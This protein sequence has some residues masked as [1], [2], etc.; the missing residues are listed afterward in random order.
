MKVQ[1]FFSNFFIK[2]KHFL[3]FGKEYEMRP[4]L[5]CLST[6]LFF[7]IAI[8]RIIK[9]IENALLEWKMLFR[10]CISSYSPMIAIQKKRKLAPFETLCSENLKSRLQHE[11]YK[12]GDSPLGHETVRNVF[13]KLQKYNSCFLNESS[14]LRLN[15]FNAAITGL[16]LFFNS[17]EHQINLDRFSML[18]FH[19]GSRKEVLRKLE[20]LI[21][22]V[23]CRRKVQKV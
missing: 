11:E 9:E 14:V 6:Y 7:R 1:L 8:V 17:C 16:L 4:H 21:E 15:R 12:S 10:K 2:R 19:L 20:P 23:M 3:S 18:S 13:P 22:G 5:T